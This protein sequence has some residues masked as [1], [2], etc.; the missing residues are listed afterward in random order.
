ME[1]AADEGWRSLL[2]PEWMPILAVLLCGVLLQS[3]NVLMLSTVLPTIVG[4]LG[5]VTMMSWPT[6]AYLASSI[7]AATCA[8]VFAAVIGVRATYCAGVTVFGVGSLLCSVAP[9]MEWIVAGRLVQGFGGGLEAAVAYVVVRR[10]LP[11]PAWPRAIALV[12]GM[13]SVSVLMGPLVG[14][15]F[16]RWGD[17]RGAFVLVSAI[18]AFLV[19]GAFVV[20]RPA[21]Q[22]RKQPAPRVPAARVAL[23]CLAIAATS[24]AS[25]AATPIAE[26]GLI[27]VSILALTLMLRLNR[28]AAT[29]LLPRDSFLLHT[30]TG[31]GLWLVLLLCIT[32]SPLQ[33]YVPIFLQRLHGLDPLAAGYAVAGASM[34]W[35]AASLATAGA[36]GLWR[37]RLML[38]G[39]VT[40]GIGLMGIALL[41]PASTSPGLYVAIALVGVGIGQCWPFVAHRVMSGA[42]SGDETVA[43]SSV[44]TVQQM[45][46]ALGAALAGLAANASGLGNE[47][48]A[49]DMATAAFWVPASFVAPA[50]IACLAGLRLNRR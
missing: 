49:D 27:V 10:T 16:A 45:G 44:P 13:W 42:R 5:G 2:K 22:E 25:A 41:M 9:T 17:W 14:G 35:T 43:A 7:T 34:G 18:A 21:A 47:V 46:F 12:S 31:V 3:M 38:A 11:E 26:I 1:Q 23:I 4:E 29:P 37:D 24:V 6:T 40:M 39:P 32:Y 48:A 33:L 8:A 20:L 19:V 28:D 30:P 36:V 15:V 50:A